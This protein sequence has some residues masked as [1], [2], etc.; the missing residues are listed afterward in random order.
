MSDQTSRVKCPKCGLRGAPGS[1][2]EN[3]CG[4]LPA[5]EPDQTTPDGASNET[6]TPESQA[7]EASVL[8]ASV[9]A[10]DRQD[11]A[12]S[13]LD[14]F[15]AKV[16]IAEA[17]V[18]AAQAFAQ[19]TGSDIHVLNVGSWQAPVSRRAE[20]SEDE[21]RA[22]RHG[23]VHASPVTIPA[24][25][26]YGN[27]FASH[28]TTVGDSGQSDLEECPVVLEGCLPEFCIVGHAASLKFRVR[29]SQGSIGE[30]TRLELRQDDKLLARSLEGTV[31]PGGTMLAINFT[32][33]AA[34]DIAVRLVLDLECSEGE[35]DAEVYETDP[36]DIVVREREDGRK[37]GN[38]TLNVTN[39]VNVDRAG[40]ARI[41]GLPSNFFDALKNANGS[42]ADAMRPGYGDRPQEFRPFT[43]HAHRL[44]SRYTLCGAEGLELQIL[45][46]RAISF[47]RSRENDVA[48]R[49]FNPQG[50]LDQDLSRAISRK[51]FVV[52]YD[53]GKCRIFDCGSSCGTSLSGEDLRGSESLEVEHEYDITVAP[54][55][56]GGVLALKARP[57]KCPEG[58]ENVCGGAGFR[59]TSVSSLLITRTDGA[60]KKE[61]YLA[62]WKC[63]SLGDVMPGL[64][65]YFIHWDGTRF[66]VETPDGGKVPLRSNVEFGPRDCSVNVKRFQQNL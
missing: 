61:A 27:P 53:E 62:V 50:R 40:D 56:N 43:L 10:Q 65:G 47:G 22:I 11:A 2:C 21:T 54:R 20:S 1:F 45:S 33:Q 25:F 17:K 48:L 23:A 32:P 19:K 41:E 14:A 36:F 3:G 31:R 15:E 49:V 7:A 38:V 8:P 52:S 18:A 26:T 44:P 46:S 55:A 57:G 9:M 16:E 59:R 6:A 34:G 58:H 63:A 4:R 35:R 28:G 60:E 24:D 12:F 42:G 5:S 66:I 30:K 13:P 51:H 64:E 37:A 29:A 39:H